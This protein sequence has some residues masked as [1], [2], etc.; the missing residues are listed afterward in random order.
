[1]INLSDREFLASLDQSGALAS[2]QQLPLQIEAGWKETHKLDLPADYNQVHQVIV[3]GMGASWLGAHIIQNL[4]L[5]T[6]KVPL[7]ISNDYEIP[8]FVGENSLVIASSYS[9]TT[10]ETISGMLKAHEKKAKIITISTGG[11]LAEFAKTNHLPNY[12]FAGQYNPAKSPRLGLGYSMAAQISILK[13]LK[14]ITFD[15]K[16][17]FTAINHLNTRNIELLPE[18]HD[19]Q[20]MKQA[21]QLMGFMPIVVSGPFLLGNAHAWSNQFNETSKTFATYMQIP[22]L[23]HHNLEGLAH[24]SEVQKLKYLFI[25]SDMYDR[26]ISKR[27]T[28]TKEVL[29]QNQVPYESY[30]PQGKTKIVQS[31]DV[32]LFG[33]YVTFYLAMLYGVDPSPNPYVDYFKKRLQE[34]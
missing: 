3:C 13:Q 17:I 33:S 1:M 18:A 20:A 32:L 2:I 15:E 34:V 21:Q 9:G 12:T 28:V 14:L 5:S 10:E 27:I 26:R 16:E 25:E 30:S 6:L 19:N 24:P 8:D 22:E 7:M 31:F 23:N 4:F 11:V 29:Q